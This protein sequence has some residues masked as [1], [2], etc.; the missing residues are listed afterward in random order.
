MKQL[1]QLTSRILSSRRPRLS[2]RYF[3]TLRKIHA[4]F[5]TIEITF[6]PIDYSFIRTKMYQTI[7]NLKSP[8][9]GDTFRKFVAFPSPHYIVK[10]F[11]KKTYYR[12]SSRTDYTSGYPMVIVDFVIKIYFFIVEN[13]YRDWTASLWYGTRFI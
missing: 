11:L 12:L 5:A 6:L 4:A 7:A 1:I 13:Y 10:A 3:I 2:R 8:L 9:E